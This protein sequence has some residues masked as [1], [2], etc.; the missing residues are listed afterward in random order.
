[1]AGIVV[2]FNAN[3]KK[4]P[5]LLKA[6]HFSLPFRFIK[7][8]NMACR[9]FNKYV[10]SLEDLIYVHRILCVN[11]SHDANTHVKLFEEYFHKNVKIY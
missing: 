1:M 10:N 5:L 2:N 3:L 6:R 4:K 7:S 9:S 8:T 11:C